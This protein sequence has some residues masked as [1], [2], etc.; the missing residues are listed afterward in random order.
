MVIALDLNICRNYQDRYY[1]WL[2]D[3]YHDSMLE[4]RLWLMSVV[5]ETLYDT[6]V[7][8]EHKVQVISLIQHFNHSYH[9]R[10]YVF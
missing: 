9:A 2:F 7:S 3:L 6:D 8:N 10:C 5:Y 1:Q 4:F